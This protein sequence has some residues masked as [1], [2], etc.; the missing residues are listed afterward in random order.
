V[1]ARQ[2]ADAITESVL[3]ALRIALEQGVLTAEH[4]PAIA[5]AAGNNA[6][7]TLDIEAQ[8]QAPN[9]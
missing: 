2:Q 1:T 4:L 6:A 9:A 3:A 8:L 7:M 5:R